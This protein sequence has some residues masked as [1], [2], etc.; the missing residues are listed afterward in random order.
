MWSLASA[1]AD[2]PDH[3]EHPHERRRQSSGLALGTSIFA[4]ATLAIAGVSQLLTGLVAIIDGRTF[5]VT[6][7]N[8]VFEFNATTWGWIHIVLG[9]LSAVAGIFIFTGN[10]LARSVGIGLACLSIISN[11]L[12]LPHY[13]LWAIVVIAID[14]VVI[15]ALATSSLGEA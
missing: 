2:P 13:P 14:V 3:D 8:Y 5:L 4:G 12:F 7:T 6:S 9:L 1:S 11:F 10:L 15:W